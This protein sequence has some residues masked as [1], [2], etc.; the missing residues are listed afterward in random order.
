MSTVSEMDQVPDLRRMFTGQVV[1]QSEGAWK[2]ECGD[3][4]GPQGWLASD[5]SGRRNDEFKTSLSWRV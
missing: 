1:D 5:R 4:H 2:M 3:V